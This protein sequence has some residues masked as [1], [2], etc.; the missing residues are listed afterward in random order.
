MMCSSPG[1]HFKTRS[2][3]STMLPDSRTLRRN[4]ELLGAK[5][6]ADML[7]DSGLECDV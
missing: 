5:A 7:G 3:S 1:V 4:N 2:D 6:M